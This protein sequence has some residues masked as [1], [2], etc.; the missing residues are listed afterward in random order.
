VFSF[1]LSFEMW[2]YFVCFSSPY[3][4]PLSLHIFLYSCWSG[5]PA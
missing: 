5:L 3:I 4:A 1:N 2:F